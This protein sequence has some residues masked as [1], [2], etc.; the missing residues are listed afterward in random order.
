MGGV[1]TGF[2]LV[3]NPLKLKGFEQVFGHSKTLVS[4]EL[5]NNR[6][7]DPGAKAL[8]DALKVYLTHCID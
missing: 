3:F 6:I 5:S 7:G 4:V 1:R 8:A 2:W